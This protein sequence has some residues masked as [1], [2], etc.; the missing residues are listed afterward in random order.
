MERLKNKDDE[1]NQVI[2]E[3]LLS[4][5]YNS[6]AEALMSDT[7]LKK[8][9]ASKGSLLERRWGTIV[10][11]QKKVSDL[12]N[13]VKVLKEDMERAGSGGSSNTPGYKK[14]NESMVRI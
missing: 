5:N 11:L 13:Q 2:L 3:W 7:G 1:I 14:D 8:E 9:D 12:E 10:V 4:K 6:A